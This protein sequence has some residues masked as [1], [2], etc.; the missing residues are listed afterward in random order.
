MSTSSNITVSY[1]ETICKRDAVKFAKHQQLDCS[2]LNEVTSPLSLNFTPDYIELL[3]TEKNTSIHVDF[4]SGSVAH[5][6]QFG[7]GKGQAIAKAMGLKTA[8]TKPSVLDAT[9]GLARDAYVIATLGCPIT[10][11]EQSPIIAK[12][13]TDG[14]DRACFDDNFKLIMDTGFT[15]IQQNCI[16]Y[17]QTV[18]KIP[19]VIYLDPMYP[20]RKKSALVKKNM[21]ILQKLLGVDQNAKKLL[22]VALQYAKNRVVVKRPRGE[23]SISTRIPDT[24]I[25]SKQTRYDIYFT[26]KK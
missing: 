5:R 9:A 18:T 16:D 10:M 7:G 24:A 23:K 25:E 1:S 3:D 14:I 6:H 2:A 26:F 17:L 12:L 15:I 8:K 13:V 19:D 22:D 21:Q 11:V 4:L 20:D